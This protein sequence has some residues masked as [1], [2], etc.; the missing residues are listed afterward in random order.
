M[1]DGFAKERKA[2]DEFQKF[3]DNAENVRRLF[4]SAGLP[5]PAPLA[6]ALGEQASDAHRLGRGEKN[7]AALALPPRP[8][9]ADIDWIA[10]PVKE[11]TP[12]VLLLAILRQHNG[13]VE[14]KALS[15]G[16]RRYL[17]AVNPGSIFNIVARLAQGGVLER[18][19][20]GARLINPSNGLILFEKYAWGPV[21]NFG[22]YEL[23][24]HRRQLIRQL[25]S[26]NPGGLQI[27]QI[28]D[29][30]Q[31]SGMCKAPATKDLLKTDMET[32]RKANQ[33]RRVSNSKKWVLA[34]ERTNGQAIK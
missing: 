31:E 23:A 5:L 2:Y 7:A 34:E 13:Y 12:M 18:S 22:K 6:R 19:E 16:V 11:L 24:S 26:A 28:L 30:L 29:Q 21:E 33:V 27:M 3:L 1:V 8:S 32:M 15:A 4:K 10:V 17:P 14:N 25:L 20:E 9:D